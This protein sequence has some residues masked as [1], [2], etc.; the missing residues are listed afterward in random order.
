MVKKATKFGDV[1]QSYNNTSARQVYGDMGQSALDKLRGMSKS[2][3]TVEQQAVLTAVRQEAAGITKTGTGTL[4]IFGAEI[5]AAGLF[6]PDDIDRAALEDIGEILISFERHIQ[7]LI[8]DF[9]VSYEGRKYGEIAQIAAHFGY[10]AKTLYN[11]RNACES[12]TISLRREVLAAAPEGKTLGISHYELVQ[13]L[14]IAEQKR[15]LIEA[16]LEGLPVAELRKRIKGASLL[17]P[18]R[19]LPAL[20]TDERHKRIGAIVS[21]IKSGKSIDRQDIEAVRAW[22]DEVENTLS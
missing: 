13:G 19:Q 2:P 18:V 16:R 10:E 3:P 1:E 15:W 8:G 17:D 14:D 12:V 11:W 7:V 6:I 5:T 22:L 9:L 21:A 4:E 20:V